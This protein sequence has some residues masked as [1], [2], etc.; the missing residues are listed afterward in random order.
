MPSPNVAMVVLDTLR[1]DAFDDHF[2]WLPGRRYERAWAP[3]HWTVPVHASVF[4][5]KYASEVGSHAKSKSLDTDDP[6]IAEQLSGAGYRTRAFTN[7]L[8]VTR[9]NDFDRGFDEVE[10]S[11]RLAMVDPD[12]DLFDWGS[13]ILETSD[14][15]ITRYPRAIWRILRGDCETLGSLK[16]GAGLKLRH[17]GVGPY[18]DDGA[19]ATLEY[20]RDGEVEDE[21]EFLFVNLMEAH[22]PYVAP[23]SYQTT[24][25]QAVDELNSTVDAPDADPAAI[26]G[27]Y[28]DCVR[29]LSDKY[30]EIF[31]HLREDYDYVITF[32]DHGDLLGEHDGWGHAYGLYPEL[33]HVPLTVWGDGVEDGVDDATVSL[34]DVHRT[35]LD[36]AG[37]EGDSRGRNL[38]DDPGDA[39]WITEYHGL[40]RQHREGLERAGFGDAAEA[41]DRPFEGVVLPG[42]YGYETDE[43]WVEEG[44]PGDDDPRERLA[45]LADDLDRRPIETDEHREVSEAVRAQLEELGYA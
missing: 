31:E 39:E 28:D 25:P 30:R 36:L 22:S 26:R 37:V 34:L 14:E 16:F 23:R 2:D 1:K 18:A 24:D 13:F 3:S 4:T 17:Y 20:V 10:G 15:G 33:V 19:A 35:V 45:A 38:L 32:S 40:S 9:R 29:Y 6:T 41:M 7:N 11:W 12:R 42:Y 43:G 21:G 27:A 5:G 8:N 44:S